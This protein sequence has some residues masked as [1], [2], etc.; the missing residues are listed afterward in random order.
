M[1]VCSEIKRRIDEADDVE[2]FDIEVSRHTDACADCRRFAGERAALRQLLATAAKVTAP[3]NFNAVLEA[4]LADVKSRPPLAWLN[5]AFYLRVGAATAALAV[6]VL[7]AQ[8]NGLFNR[9]RVEPAPT[10][11]VADATASTAAEIQRQLSWQFMN[12][13]AP[14]PASNLLAGRSEVAVVAM[15]ARAGN[16]LRSVRRGAGVPLLAPVDAAFVD[17][18]AILIPGK[19]GGHDITVPTVSVGAQPMIYVNAGRQPQTGRAV[20]VSF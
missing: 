4:R 11:A 17:S 8:Y 1:K 20:P 3:P 16:H 10:P 19:N 14:A 13:P 2:S 6:A 15:D 7:V 18:G 12:P 9:S 5:A